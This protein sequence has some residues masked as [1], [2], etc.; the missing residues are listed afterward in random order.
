MIFF[1]MLAV[2]A[3]EPSAYPVADVAGIQS[4]AFNSKGELV[5]FDAFDFKVYLFQPDGKLKHR[6]GSQGQGPGE[7]QNP[8]SLAV[9]DNDEIVT[10]DPVGRKL[11]FF[12]AAGEH[13]RTVSVNDSALGD[14][15]A[16]PGNRLLVTSSS[17]AFLYMKISEELPK[18]FSLFDAEGTLLSAFGTPKT[19]EQHFL[20]AFLN[21]GSPVWLGDQLL[22]FNRI[23]NELDIYQNGKEKRLRYKASFIP[24]TP[25]AKTVTT[26]TPDG[27]TN[28]QIA[29]DSDVVSTSA[30]AWGKDRVLLLRTIGPSDEDGAASVQLVAVNLQGKVEKE[31]PGTFEGAETL[32]VTPDGR[33][34]LIPNDADEGWQ[35]VKVALQN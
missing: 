22:F 25:T 33:H 2:L 11:L 7:F 24:K 27:K 3:A 18:R 16:A 14:I 29:M 34:A 28:M 12:D 8:T 26:K 6:F 17:V 23:E 9:L 31:F 1:C 4:L 19:H 5:L 35:L 13:L 32:V 20:G 10:V 30:V 21:Q 15:Y